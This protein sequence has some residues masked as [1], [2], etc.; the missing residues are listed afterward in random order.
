MNYTISVEQIKEAIR[1]SLAHTFAVP[2]ENATDE[3]YYKANAILV[4]TLLA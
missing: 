1:D 2:L 4:R 3:A